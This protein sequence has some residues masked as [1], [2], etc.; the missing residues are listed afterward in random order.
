M[1]DILNKF[2]I[3]GQQIFKQLRNQDLA[4]SRK[5]GKSWDSFLNND[6]LLWKRR[7]QK[8][9]QYQNDFKETWK[10]LMKN[11]PIEILK[12][13]AVKIGI[14]FEMTE[15]PLD[16]QQPPLPPPLCIIASWGDISLSEYIIQRVG[17]EN[18]VG[19]DGLTA[20]HIAAKGGFLQVFK[21]IAGH[22][23]NSNPSKNDGLTPLHL[24]A[25]EGHLEVVK[26]IAGNLKNKNP[27]KNDGWTPYHSA[28]KEGHLEVIKYVAGY[29]D[30]KNPSMNDGRT[31]LHL[32]A[33]GGHLEV[34]K[35]ISRHL[36]NKNP[37]DG[38]GNTPI[39]LAKSA[40]QFKVAIFLNAIRAKAFLWPK[41]FL[42]TFITFSF[43]FVLFGIFFQLLAF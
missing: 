3:L 15:D 23:E 35:Y 29:L 41:P 5:V 1:D 37:S 42:C 36:D 38:N 9:Y 17:M 32:A 30:D 8:Y 31:P 14:F 25:E 22:L 40:G 13:L 26:Q 28:A 21:Y 10:L 39:S 34:V 27:A 43:L 4:N 20:L 18:S 11:A 16:H 12:K 33:Q 24:A 6:S 19:K 2:P 7:I